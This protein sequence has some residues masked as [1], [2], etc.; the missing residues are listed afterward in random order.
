MI[1]LKY[2]H[3]TGIAASKNVHKINLNRR[4]ETFVRENVGNLIH[5][6]RLKIAWM[7]VIVKAMINFKLACK[8]VKIKI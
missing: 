5:Q 3:W 1:A 8:D 2:C 7:I 4:L 6:S